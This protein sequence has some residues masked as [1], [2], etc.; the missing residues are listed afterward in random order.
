MRF[1]N[2]NFPITPSMHRTLEDTAELSAE[3]QCGEMALEDGAAD[4]SGQAFGG[5][6]GGKNCLY[7]EGCVTERGSHN[8]ASL[9]D[10]EVEP[11]FINYLFAPQ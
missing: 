11:V 4:P 1:P 8:A 10:P 2:A 9:T 5:A 7:V 6:V 3:A